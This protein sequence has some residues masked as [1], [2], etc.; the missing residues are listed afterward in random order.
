MNE[1]NNLCIPILLVIAFLFFAGF[2]IFKADRTVESVRAESKAAVERQRI[3]AEQYKQS[4]DK[5]KSA[6]D[7]AKRTADTI[8]DISGQQREGITSSLQIIGELREVSTEIQNNFNSL[9]N[10]CRC[11]SGSV[12]NKEVSE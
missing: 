4:Y 10:T 1:K 5:L 2:A 8:S 6:N 9:T 7:E 3:I 11:V 12:D